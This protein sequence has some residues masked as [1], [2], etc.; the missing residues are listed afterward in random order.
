MSRRLAKVVPNARGHVRTRGYTVV[1]LMMATAIFAVGI[2]GVLGLEIVA[3]QSN[4]QARDVAVATALA[5]S[6]QD[7]L[8]M[9]ATLWGGTGNWN[10]NQTRWLNL[11]Q[12]SNN[13]W[14][15][16][17]NDATT[18][19]GPAADRRGRFV[20][21]TSTPG[22]AYF[23]THIRLTQLITRP[24]SGLIRTE[25]RVFWPRGPVEWGTNYCDPSANVAAI[26]ASYAAT[27]LTATPNTNAEGQLEFLYKTSAVRETP[28]F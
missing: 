23:C 13:T 14:I 12:T 6:W 1:E 3:A 15:L 28:R 26:G 11:V 19:F 22:A 2:T 24:G 18:T 17:P 7:R 9:D 25:V 16:P 5:R 4:S 8:A 20:D 27:T 21:H 10:I